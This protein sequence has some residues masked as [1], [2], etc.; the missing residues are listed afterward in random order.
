[1]TVSKVLLNGR[2]LLLL[3]RNAVAR[4]HVAVFLLKIGEYLHQRIDAGEVAVI[5]V[6]VAGVI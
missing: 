2:K 3:Q 1:M 4:A 6:A 5:D